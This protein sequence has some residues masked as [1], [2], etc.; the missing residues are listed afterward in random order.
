MSSTTPP[1]AITLEQLTGMLREA[2]ELPHGAVLSIRSRANPAFNST[3]EHLEVRYT[4]DAPAEAPRR[5]FFKRSLPVE[6]ARECGEAEVAFYRL[7]ADLPDHP[8]MTAR[9][10]A[11]GIDPQTHDSFVLLQDVSQTH[12]APLTRDQ[13]IAKGGAVPS[14]DDIPPVVEAL[15]RF[16]AYWHQHPLLGSE[17][18][19]IAHWFQNAESYIDYTQRRI[20]AWEAL[21][22]DEADCP[23]DEIARYYDL[24]I[25]RMPRLWTRFWE[26][27]IATR[28]HLTLTHGDAYF[29]NFLCPNEAGAAPTYLIDWQSP[30]AFLGA[31][32]LATLIASFWTSAQ[33]NEHQREERMLRRYHQTLLSYGVT[34][35]SWEAFLADYRLAL[36]DWLLVPLQDRYDGSAAGYWRPKMQCLFAA[37]C[38]HHCETLLSE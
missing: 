32:D 27:R 17:A 18:A 12:H 13:Q 35:Y 8:P 4:P 36:L 14:S 24:L 21:R 6:W 3:A 16:H 19:P 20:R 11:A 26:P 9:C 15:A 1:N 23:P 37:C 28:A 33:R 34:G 5:L 31:S 30:E 10:Y 22:R 7:V 38:D 2:G 25:S 29:A